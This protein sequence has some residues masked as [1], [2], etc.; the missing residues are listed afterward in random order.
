MGRLSEGERVELWDRWEAG[1]SQRST[2]EDAGEV[3]VD[4]EDGGGV[5][6]VAAPGAALCNGPLKPPP[7]CAEPRFVGHMSIR[8]PST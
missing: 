5:V 3:A 4:G 1:E 7:I 2:G 8:S 6:E